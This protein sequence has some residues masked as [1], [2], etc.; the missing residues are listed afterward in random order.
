MPIIEIQRRHLSII[1][2][3]K[4]LQLRQVSMRYGKSHPMQFIILLTTNTVGESRLCERQSLDTEGETPAFGNC[5]AVSE[6]M[7][8]LFLLEFFQIHVQPISEEPYRLAVIFLFLQ[9]FNFLH[10]SFQLFIV[11]D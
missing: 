7:E 9:L 2:R 8:S 5:G 10:G 3:F 1:R 4:L 11:L 6:H